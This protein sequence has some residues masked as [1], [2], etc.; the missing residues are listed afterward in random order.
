M[1]LA[2]EIGSQLSQQEI[3]HLTLLRQ[4]FQPSSTGVHENFLPSSELTQDEE[5]RLR[6]VRQRLRAEVDGSHDDENYTLSQQ[7][8]FTDQRLQ[9][10]ITHDLSRLDM[11]QY[12][13]DQA[14]GKKGPDGGIIRSYNPVLARWKF[15]QCTTPDEKEQFREY[16]TLQIV[17]MLREMCRVES[18]TIQYA[19]DKGGRLR[20]E[21]MPDEPF[22][23]VLLRGVA[24]RKKH[25]T[26]EPKRSYRVFE[27][28]E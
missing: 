21:L 11:L 14:L 25:N 5:E 16:E 23:N 28:A 10:T 9:D 24:Y 2:A 8:I 6:H 7:A 18:S 3:E 17:T 4:S 1:P 15:E 20:N 27:S 22:E 13:F 19:I 26:P 12:Q